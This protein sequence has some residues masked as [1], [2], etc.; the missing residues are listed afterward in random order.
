MCDQCLGV[1]VPLGILDTLEVPTYVSV[2]SFDC[3]RRWYGCGSYIM[4]CIH[5]PLHNSMDGR[6]SRHGRIF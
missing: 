3:L 1:C 2:M 6:V 4:E 5:I